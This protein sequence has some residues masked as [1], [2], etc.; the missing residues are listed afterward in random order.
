M[1][2]RVRGKRG[3]GEAEMVGSKVT[4]RVFGFVGGRLLISSHESVTRK[5]KVALNLY[6]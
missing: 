1:V 5:E 4:V 6:I 2:I 3:A